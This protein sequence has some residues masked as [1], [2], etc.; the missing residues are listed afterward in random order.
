MIDIILQIYL[1]RKKPGEKKNVYNVLLV[2]KTE[3]VIK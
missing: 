1:V 2:P 3:A